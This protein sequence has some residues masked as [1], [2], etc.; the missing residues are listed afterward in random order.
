VK[1]LAAAASSCGLPPRRRVLTICRMQ[2]RLSPY[3]TFRGTAR[4][5]MEFY[6]TVFGGTLTVNTYGDYHMPVDP[7][8]ENLLMHSMLEA[9]NGLSF[10][11]SDTPK[12]M[13]LRQGTNVSMAL[14]GDGEAEL[15]GYFTKLSAGGRVEQPL[16]KAAWRDSFGMLTDRFGIRWLVNIA[17]RKGG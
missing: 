13:E 12:H 11:G 15:T 5:A 3:L 17:G 6:R 8:E 2:S 1:R 7:G 9:E 10:M 14:N 4:E 16:T